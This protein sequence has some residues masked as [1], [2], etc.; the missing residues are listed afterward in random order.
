MKIKLIVEG[1]SMKPGPAIS[2]Q[3]GPAGINIGKVIVD[4]NKATLG[5]NGMKVPV[6]IDVNTKSK[7]F[8]IHVFSP[9]VAELIKK[10]IKVESGSGK[11]HEIKVGNIAF[12]SIVGIAKTKMPNLLA[13]DLR[14]AVR[15]VVG[16]CVSLGVL[17]DNKE[18]KEIEKDIV[19]GKYD[20]EIKHE[21]TIVSAEKKKEL[22]QFFA[23]RKSKQEKEQKAR[24]EAA[25]AAE[26]AKVTEATTATALATGATPAGKTPATP[27]AAAGKTPGAKEAA[28]PE[29]KKDKKK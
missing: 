20:K 10:E 22:E 11:A 15:M 25:V 12:E 8:T 13:K 16:T 27:T 9:P 21:I 23:E 26:A 5:F 14:A 29:V 17:I 7:E 1:G 2:Q 19:D 6:E 3:L 24:E 4:V 18:A 28:K